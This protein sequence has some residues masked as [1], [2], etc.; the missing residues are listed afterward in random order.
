MELFLMILI[1][2]MTFNFL[3]TIHYLDKILKTLVKL[4]NQTGE[5]R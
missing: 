2:N 1:V 5:G 3:F 4:T